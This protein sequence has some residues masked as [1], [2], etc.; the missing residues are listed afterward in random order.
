MSVIHETPSTR[1]TVNLRVPAETRGLIDR[2]AKLLGKN[3]T[4]FIL[5][6]SR[7]AAEETLL[8]QVL[9]RV[10]PAAYAAFVERLDA[11]PAPNER[12]RRTMQTPPPWSDDT[13]ANPDPT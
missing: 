5:D 13:S 3:R 6:A 2:A 10:E 11:P 7:R 8:D 12:L 9:L 4:Q 1:E